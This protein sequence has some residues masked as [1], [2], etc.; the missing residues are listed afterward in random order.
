[1]A[2]LRPRPI[3]TVIAFVSGF[4]VALMLS[5]FRLG[6]PN[7]PELDVSAGSDFPFPFSAGQE[8]ESD[9]DGDIGGRRHALAVI[10]VQ[11]SRCIS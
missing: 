1:M 2:P 4:A 3:R 10:G 7:V 8:K 9:L 6:I 11:V 5:T